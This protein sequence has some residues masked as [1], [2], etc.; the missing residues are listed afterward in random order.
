MAES[1][2]LRRLGVGDAGVMRDIVAMLPVP[3]WRSDDI[4]SIDYLASVLAD[5]RT[6][7]FGAFTGAGPVG[8]ASAY[9]FPALTAM[10]DLVYVYDVF[11]AEPDRGKGFGR[12]LMDALLARLGE[13]GV[14]EAWVGTD[15][16][17]EAARRLY[18]SAGAVSSEAYV[19]YEYAFEPAATAVA[20]GAR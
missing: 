8:F 10:Q 3:E 14:A 20:E 19:Q 11:V 17:N 13:D 15:R 1:I 4:P 12:K 2:D 7:V 6:Y 16:D 9:R 18:L 5:D